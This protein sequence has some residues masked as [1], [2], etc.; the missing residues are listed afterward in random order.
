RIMALHRRP[1]H[2]IDRLDDAYLNHYGQVLSVALGEKLKGLQRTRMAE[3]RSGNIALADA[4]AIEDKRRQIEELESKRSDRDDIYAQVGNRA[5]DDKRK[6]LT[7]GIEAILDRN[8]LEA[9]ADPANAGKTTAQAVQERLGHILATR[10]PDAGLTLGDELAKTLGPSKGGGA[11]AAMLN[12][13][14]VDVA[15]QQLLEL[16]A[17]H[18]TST[19]RLAGILRGLR[20]QAEHDVLAKAHDPW[21]AASEKQAIA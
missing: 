19:E 1:E 6:E 17:T 20:S 11:T 3:L 15:A 14:V 5:L 10:G 12:G 13:S 4:C 9:M 2:E 16:E 8:R 21:L 7:A 18:Q